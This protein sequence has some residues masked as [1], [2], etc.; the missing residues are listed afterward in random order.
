MNIT[1]FKKSLSITGLHTVLCESL[2]FFPFANY[3]G[4]DNDHD[5]WIV[6][7]FN[8]LTLCIIFRIKLVGIVYIINTGCI[9]EIG[10]SFIS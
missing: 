5:S 10:L 1:F 8:C 9:L 2:L 7:N 4:A 6:K 3:N